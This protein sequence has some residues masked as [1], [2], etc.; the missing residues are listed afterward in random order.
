MA[1]VITQYCCNDAVCVDVCPVDCIH[2]TPAEPGYATAEQLYIDPSVCVDCNA[3]LEACP[4]D[5]IFREEDL[6]PSL[7]RFA[8]INAGY[9]DLPVVAA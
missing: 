1:Y 3:C 8:E 5:A 7:A 2:P 6:L 4:V 9:Y